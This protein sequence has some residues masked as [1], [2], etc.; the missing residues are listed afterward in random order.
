[1]KQYNREMLKQELKLSDDKIRINLGCGSRKQKGY[2][3][4]DSQQ[5]DGVDIVCDVENKL[6]FADNT[7]DKVYANFLIEHI[8]DLVFFMQELYRVCCNGAIVRV[9]FPYWSSVTHWKDPTHK[10]VI[11]VETFRYFSRDK[12]YGSDYR[13]NTNF[14]V[15]SCKYVYLPPFGGKRWLFLFPFTFPLRRFLRRHLINVVHS[16]WVELQVI[17]ELE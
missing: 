10:H 9:R 17:K 16:V 3:G 5:L 6:P 13:I 11:T 14:T 7:A 4:I 12:W 15:K 1:M 2:I 8:G